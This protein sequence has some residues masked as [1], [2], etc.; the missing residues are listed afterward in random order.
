MK[1][2]SVVAIAAAFGLAVLTGCESAPRARPV[3]MGPVDTG[4]S[5]VESVRRQLQGTW[6]LVGL[7]I[8]TA[9]GTVSPEATGRLEYDEY[10]NL[11]MRGS[12]TGTA[13]VDPSVLNLTG[14]AVIDPDTKTLRL[15]AI[16]AHTA[17]DK[18]V[19]PK[20]DAQHV[21]YYEFAD[22]QLKTTVKDATGKVTATATWKKIA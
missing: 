15:Q 13:E 4:P 14:R 10:G 8:F 17:D 18:R 19:D 20:L 22:G 1:M 16:S 3:K 12:I 7:Q 21:R 6:E 11:A 2:M 5:S 9:S